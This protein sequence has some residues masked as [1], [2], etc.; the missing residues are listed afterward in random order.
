MQ[1][2]LVSLLS[3]WGENSVTLKNILETKVCM[4]FSEIPDG[5]VRD[6]VRGFTQVSF[7]L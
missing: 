4:D 3:L 1:Y 7:T 2:L 6:V 5:V